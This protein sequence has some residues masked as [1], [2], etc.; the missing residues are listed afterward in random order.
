MHP[1][2]RYRVGLGILIAAAAA[3]SVAPILKNT[4]VQDDIP[5]I[6]KDGRLH[7]PARW[8][9]FLTESYW[10]PPHYDLYRPL[11]SLSMAGEYWAGGSSVLTFRI[12]QIAL[13]AAAAIAVFALALRLMRP[14]AALAVALLFAVHPVHVE[15]AAVAVN[16]AEM[17]VGLLAALAVAWYLDRRKRGHLSMRDQAGLAGI[18]MIAAHFKESGIML[19]VL[20]FA[21]EALLVAGPPIWQRLKRI[22]GLFVWQTLA[23]VA[24]L[25]IRSSIPLLNAAGSYVGETFDGHGIGGRAL[26]MLAVVPEWLRLLLWPQSLAADYAPDRIAPATAWGSD[27]T[28][29]LLILVLVVV[30]AWRVRKRNPVFTFG[31]AWTA[32]GLFP[33]SNVLIPTSIALAERTLFLPSI[34]AMIAVGAVLAA[35][36]EAIGKRRRLVVSS[37]AAMVALVVMLGGLRSWSRSQV[38]R[39]NYSLWGQT[40]IDAPDSYHAWAAFGLLVNDIGHREAAIRSLEKSV[41][42]WDRTSGPL[43]MLADLYRDDGNCAAA[44]P[45]YKKVVA[46]SNHAPARNE[47]IACMIKLHDY[48]TARQEALEGI[49]GGYLAMEFR[50]WMRTLDKAIREDLPPDQVKYDPTL[51]APPTQRQ[52][53]TGATVAHSRP[54]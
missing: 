31:V 14:G 43:L 34:G 20:L 15:A 7:N 25:G 47:L 12:M 40:L 41:S 8:N 54:D 49:R 51:V 13:Y 2:V 1:I 21:A 37:T 27:Q 18:T 22:T 48:V 24:T 45:M 42:I 36:P 53:V 26:T 9:E 35:L 16:Q 38:W 29:G 17:I 50:V 5:V 39:N 11:S 44:I 33:V 28:V 23:V 6:V 10:P 19:P 32:I 46:L 52:S 4:W 30:L 3:G